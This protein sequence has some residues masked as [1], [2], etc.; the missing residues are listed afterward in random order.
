[1]RNEFEN[2]IAIEYKGQP[3]NSREE[4]IKAKTEEIEELLKNA[5]DGEE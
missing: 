4:W 1:M 5:V 2:T 3:A